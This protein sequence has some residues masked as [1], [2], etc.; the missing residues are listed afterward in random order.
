MKKSLIIY[1]LMAFFA[2]GASC[3]KDTPINEAPTQVQ[4]IYPSKDLLCINNN[5]NFDWSDATDPE[6]D[7]IEYNIIIASDRAMTNDVQSLTVVSSE[8]LISL[9][10][11]TAYYWKVES[12]DINNEIGSS[13]EIFAFFT[14]GD[15]IENYAP[16]T[17]EAISPLNEASVAAGS[18]NLNWNGS[19][20][21]SEDTLTYQL[22][23]G[24][25]SA[26][27]VESDLTESS[28]TITSEPGKTY[29]WK[30][31]TIDQHGAKSIGQTWS[32]TVN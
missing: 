4:L 25:N 31:N 23:F 26:I 17:A 32:F 10:K 30:V 29:F 3:S 15:G 22:F 2:V 18:V 13:S 12:I 24:E 11:E 28:Y 7:D 16:F 19:D 8:A 5:I 20:T 1:S 14:S 9:E 21:N 6:N 27:E